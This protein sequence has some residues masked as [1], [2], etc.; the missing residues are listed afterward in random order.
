M[1]RECGRAESPKAHSPGQRPGWQRRGECALKEQKLF[2]MRKKSVSLCFCPSGAQL[3]WGV[4]SP[5]CRSACPGLWALGLSARHKHKRQCGRSVRQGSVFPFRAAKVGGGRRKRVAKAEG[6][7][8][9]VRTAC[10]GWWKKEKSPSL[11]RTGIVV[12]QTPLARGVAGCG[13]VPARGQ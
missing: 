5:G 3:G 8:F 11:G 10:G 6:G 7:A 4:L 13:G 12:K 9:R 2:C 1:K